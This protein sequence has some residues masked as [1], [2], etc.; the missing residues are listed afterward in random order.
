MMKLRKIM[1]FALVFSLMCFTNVKAEPEQST[2]ANQDIQLFYENMASLSTSLSRSGSTAICNASCIMSQNRKLELELT[3]QRSKDNGYYAEYAK[4]TATFTGKGG[5]T[6]EK[7][8][9]ITKGYTYRVRTVAKIYSGTTLVE[10]TA[11]YSKTFD[12]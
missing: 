3:L 7:R 8:K 2:T 12:Y 5:K 9:A 11:V 4:W 6:L 1:C 10:A